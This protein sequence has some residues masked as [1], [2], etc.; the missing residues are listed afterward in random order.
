MR[1]FKSSEEKK[2]IKK[3]DVPRKN[4]LGLPMKIFTNVTEQLV[5]FWVGEN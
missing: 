4:I 2:L 3:K 1:L 5:Q